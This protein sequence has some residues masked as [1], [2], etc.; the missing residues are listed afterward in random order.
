MKHERLL[1]AYK[2]LMRDYCVLHKIQYR[3]A[4]DGGRIKQLLIKGHSLSQW[5]PGE[6]RSLQ[7][8]INRVHLMPE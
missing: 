2:V 3:D 5:I 4:V 1:F 6:W 8:G 7:V